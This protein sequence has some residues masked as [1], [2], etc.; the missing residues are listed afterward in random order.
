MIVHRFS[1]RLLWW[2]QIDFSRSES[3]MPH[4]GFDNKQISIS[5]NGVTRKGMAQ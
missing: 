3:R 5:I 1:Q 2:V 4:Q